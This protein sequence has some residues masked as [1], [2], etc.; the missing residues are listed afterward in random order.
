MVMRGCSL[1]V[2]LAVM[3]MAACGGGGEEVT[4][5]TGVE[6]G[7]AK[8]ASGRTDSVVLQDLVTK[9]NALPPD[10]G[11]VDLVQ[12]VVL[13]EGEFGWPCDSATDC[14]SGFCILTGE[15]KICTDTCETEC[16]DGYVCSPS[17]TLPDLV[18]ICLPRFDKLCQPCR[19]HKDCQP[20]WGAGTDLCLSYGGEGSYCGAECSTGDCPA[21]YDCV[22]AD[23]PDGSQVKQCRL[24]GDGLCPCTALSKYLMLSTDCQVENQHG[25]CVG[26]RNCEAAGLS[27]CDAPVPAG[28]VCDDVDNDCDG[29]VDNI[30][31]KV[32]LVENSFGACEGTTACILGKEVCQGQSPDKEICDGNDND[33]NG[34]V[35]EGFPNADS[36]EEADCIDLDDDDDSILD[37]QD[38]CPLAANTDQAD[39]DFDQQGDVCDADDDNDQVLDGSDCDPL[40]ANVY[41]YAEELCDGID[42]DCDGVQDE[43]SCGDDNPCT[44]DVCDPALGC[45][46]VYNSNPCNDGNPCTESDHCSFGAC[47]GSFLKCD[48]GNPCTANSC[49][50]AV[51]CT[52]TY[53]AGPCDDGNVCTINDTCQD[54]SCTGQPSGCECNSDFDCAKYEDGDKC[55]GTLACN[56]NSAPFK[57]LVDP[58][59]VITCQL[60]QGADPV[61][62]KAQCLPAT[63]ACTAVGQNEGGVCN[64]N[65]LCTV[66]EVCVSGECKGLV[67]D[68]TD[69]NSCT[70]DYCDEQN[71]CQHSYNNSPCDDG[72]LCTIGD[73]CQGGACLG[74]A[75]L[76]CND[77]N[78]CTNDSCN[79]DSGCIHVNTNAP[80]NDSNACTE[81]DHC[82]QGV[83]I[84][85]QLKDCNDSNTC[86]NDLCD[87]ATGCK[88]A[89]NEAPCNDGNE[90]TTGDVCQGGQ[91]AGTGVQACNDFNPCTTDKCEPGQGCIHTLNSLPCDDS[92]ACTMNDVCANGVCAGE[93]VSCDDSSVCTSD[94]CDAAVGCKFSPVPGPCEDG[95]PCTVGDSCQLGKCQSGNQL[96]CDDDNPCTKDTCGGVGGCQYSAL[97]G[98]QCN[99]GNEC[100][101]NDVCVNGVCSGE[102]N[103]GCCLK[104][105]D[106][107]DGN[108]CT[109]DTCVLATGQCVSQAAPM[110]GLGCNADNNG[111]TT[112]DTCSNGQCI[113]GI[114]MDCSASA[115][116]CN[117]AICQSTGV[118]TYKCTLVPMQSGT[119]CDDKQFCTENDAC[120][121]AGACVG[122]TP[123]DCSQ[124]GG[125]CIDGTCNEN[126]NKCEGAPLPNGTPCNADD[127]G[128]T[129]GDSCQ[130]GDCVP[131]PGADCSW[132]DTECILGL[133]KPVGPD[134]PEGF[135]CQ[136]QFKPSGTGC[137]D[138]QY[139]TINDA[140]DGAGWCASGGPNPCHGVADACNN[141]A[142]NEDT[143]T[144][145]PAPK[146]N[147]TSCNDGDSCTMGDECLNGVCAGA[148]NICGE[149][150]VST[151][152]TTAD[153]VRPAI[154]D[155]QDGRY[156]ILWDDSSQDR[157]YGR[158]YTDSWSKEWT[159]FTPYDG[160][161]DNLE[162]DADGFDSG[163]YVAA[164]VHR[165]R[166]HSQ[167]SKNC[168]R[169]GSCNSG[170]CDE[171]SYGYSW[172]PKY[173]GSRQREERIVISW[174]DAL[175]NQTKT[176]TTYNDVDT[177]SWSLDC[178]S[179][180]AYTY[181]DPFGRVRVAA[182]PSGNAV[183]MYQV[184][185][186][187]KAVLYN[188]SGGVI[189]DFGNIGSG[190]S[191]FDVATHKDDTFIIVW[192][193]G[194]DILG[195]LYTP[196]G[197]PDGSQ[198]TI[199]DAAGTQRWPAVDTYYN[200]RFVVTWQ[201]DGEFDEDIY[202]RIF[203]KDGS[204]VS[205][206]ALKV[207][208]TDNG[209]ETNPAVGAYD[210]EGSFVV[211]WEGT[212]SNGSGIF[213]QFY[214][215][216]GMKVGN[217]KI[218]NVKL[219]GHQ[220]DP[221]VKV[222]A[223]GDGMLA[224]RGG[225]AHVW[226]RKYDANGE[227]LT[228]SEELVH[229]QSVDH[230]Q[231]APSADTVAD[232][233]Y[234]VTWE[235]SDAQGDID[236]VARL[237][238]TSGAAVSDEVAVNTTSAGWQN[239]PDLAS[240]STGKFVVVW[241]SYAQ[242][243]DVEGVYYSRFDADGT[244]LSEEIQVNQTTEY[245]QYEP[246]VAVDRTPGFDGYAAFVWTSFLH[247]GGSDYDVMARC[248]SPSDN[249]VGA[250][251]MVNTVVENDQQMPDIAW[252][253][254]GPSR[255]IVVWG[256]KNE[257][258]DN[259]G[260]YAQ[261]LSSSCSKQ[262]QPFMVNTTT[263]NVQSQPAVASASDGSFVV[264]W[265]S[266][267]QDG[268][269]Y[270]V[271]AQRY[272]NS[273]NA[274]GSEFRL[275]LITAAEQSSPAVAFLT[276]D[277]L[278]AGW[279]TI[280]E[281]ENGSAVKFL[282][283]N[284]DFS[285][286]KLDLLGNIYYQGNQ[287]SPVIVPLPQ[288]RYVAL[289]RSEGQDGDA[290]SIVGRL[291]P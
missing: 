28:E 233:G 219:T 274:D 65:S 107:D 240:D 100:T 188:P 36:D 17:G 94:A 226:A 229:N 208:T 284:A 59:S 180:A 245:E 49:D 184:A 25:T 97:D 34:F 151:F 203:K 257:D 121:G 118:Q 262:G 44:D 73:A 16:P 64:D 287:D 40:N 69:G 90:C 37:G 51:G 277:T 80:C 109:K 141:G 161:G 264:S 202:A 45:Q 35:D 84:G 62:S 126:T 193:N 29:V 38:N 156:A 146:Q 106:C 227:A 149:Y 200:G 252:L 236:I 158:S 56:K 267:N 170:Y 70:D 86:T 120:D 283:F 55:N 129:Q 153:N 175:N 41:P 113:G 171:C 57:C 173:T 6:D 212:D 213:A 166:T 76:P 239:A 1:T 19:E 96:D 159:E 231:S 182:S 21:G 259:W 123:L 85:G 46:N 258:G 286:D 68:C 148:S 87:P 52:F 162:V 137:E 143:D 228:D 139:C 174:F 66:N 291:L 276:D 289:W 27:V 205:P 82:E 4:P 5:D 33:C 168:K 3:L 18:Y 290:G 279:K 179:I 43:G 165:K 125:G 280:S 20:I 263:A 14:N 256:S 266:L 112:G 2:F 243:G 163:G 30:E 99:D 134:N 195:Q 72:N 93:A 98:A 273:G 79:P 140:C 198:I 131:G 127:N 222:L 110:N 7:G 48:D 185:N 214:N 10:Y 196:D 67:K 201:S 71:G 119:P 217:E 215:K 154:A 39:F 22:L 81:S 282:H 232:S 101:V 255:Y 189:K 218:V 138:G 114:P 58:G 12:E 78:A 197:V 220:T 223:N 187:V 124:A 209:D 132:L 268:S 230:E 11:G 172:T 178:S 181:T 249:P 167:S 194:T 253:P 234:V 31:E 275:N 135:D 271:Y 164:F 176:V 32:C 9:D 248:F 246:A 150:K 145:S 190:W 83:C 199:S 111:C 152:H 238:D 278:L 241:Q 24:S 136:S 160:G 102:G 183:L 224:W 250:E 242:D 206:Q 92:N 247:P 23:T 281:D 15:K 177:Q 216:N 244:A 122:G 157:F 251:F 155:L 288:M 115:D 130:N 77:N 60:P 225:D 211:A 237:F 103:P 47:S 116:D 192:S 108:Q 8:D 265:R 13:V 272:D 235:N 221:Q 53:K 117:D 61:C 260:I 133:C 63:G 142:C 147:G 42:N 269:N 204:P 270:G 128:C 105:S 88:Y 169:C 186:A 261:R 75:P 74:G 144:C 210:V 191:G 50:P 207:N 26:Q 104:D 95:D 285:A 89:Y 254:L 54:G 91:C